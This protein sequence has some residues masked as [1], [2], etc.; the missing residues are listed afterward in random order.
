MSRR[1]ERL[2]QIVQI[3]SS[4]RL[5]TAVQLAERLEVSER[6][7]YRDIKDLSLSGV[8][9][10]GEAGRGYH[11][12]AGYHLPPLMFS[13]DE[14]EALITAL[15]MVKTWS[16][17]ALACSA[18]TAHEKLLAVLSPDKRLVAEQSA[19]AVPDFASSP[20][21]KQNFDLFH[22]AIKTRKVVQMAYQDKQGRVSRRR[23]HPLGLTFWGK[24][25]LLVAWCE[26]R[27]DYRSF[28]LERCSE[29]VLTEK[30]FSRHPQRSLEHFIQ[31]QRQ[32]VKEISSQ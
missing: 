32:Q 10:M 18:G 14:V 24:I 20:Q 21:V 31:Q 13:S 28:R 19:I 25:W 16:G 1:S 6:T 4:R 5:T 15:Q 30:D 29:I 12:L 17:D 7:I 3:I 9:V 8:P 11:L 26:T 22:R 27:D 23:V 2:F